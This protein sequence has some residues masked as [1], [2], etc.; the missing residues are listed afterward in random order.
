MYSI[1]V[2]KLELGNSSITSSTKSGLLL[3]LN[4][5]SLSI[6]A[7]WKYTIGYSFTLLP[8]LFK[9][10]DYGSLTALADGVQLRV[11]LLVGNEEGNPH[12][13]MT[14]CFFQVRDFDISFSGPSRLVMMISLQINK[15]CNSQEG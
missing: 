15:S 7:D 9:F 2:T 8:E 14:A 4:D 5:S 12:I 13:N 10:S 11:G 6:S 3:A 1:N